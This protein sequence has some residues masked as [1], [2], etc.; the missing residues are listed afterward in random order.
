MVDPN[1]DLSVAMIAF[2]YGGL[3]PSIPT[4]SYQW[5]YFCLSNI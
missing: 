2:G 1:R 4:S 3:E 5:Q